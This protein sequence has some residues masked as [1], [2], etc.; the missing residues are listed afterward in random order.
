MEIT[1]IALVVALTTIVVLFIRGAFTDKS[2]AGQTIS[3]IGT[4]LRV[5]IRTSTATKL[6]DANQRIKELSDGKDVNAFV[7]ELEAF[8]TLLSELK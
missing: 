5:N 8:N 4:N 3:A 6:A 1:M 2:E 7:K